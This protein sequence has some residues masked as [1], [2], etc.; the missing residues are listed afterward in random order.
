MFS[1]HPFRSRPPDLRPGGGETWRDG[2]RVIVTRIEDN[3]P[4]DYMA[5]Q[6]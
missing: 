2:W 5:N 6:M 4:T 3:K 1:L